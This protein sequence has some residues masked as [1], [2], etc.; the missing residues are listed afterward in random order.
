MKG[1]DS[2]WTGSS[3]GSSHIDQFL[4]ALGRSLV[5]CINMKFRCN[6][7]GPCRVRRQVRHV[8]VVTGDKNDLE[9]LGR[10]RRGQ[11]NPTTVTSFGLSGESISI[12]LVHSGSVPRAE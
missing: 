9:I 1:L 12:A 5:K 10:N 11:R 7:V 6:A 2:C 8:T 4:L 3:Q